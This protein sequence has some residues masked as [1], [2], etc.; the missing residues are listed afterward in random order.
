MFTG[1]GTAVMSNDHPYNVLVLP[2]D[3]SAKNNV[4]V[5]FDCFH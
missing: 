4:H 1:S 3:K 2:A 5:P